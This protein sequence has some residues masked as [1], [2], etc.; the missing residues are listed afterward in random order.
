ME[1][2]ANEIPDAPACVSE[3]LVVAKVVPVYAGAAT[4]S[5]DGNCQE[6]D[7]PRSPDTQE[8]AEVRKNL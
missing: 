1:E 8:L 3:F 7:E 4:A 2:N 5:P 6:H